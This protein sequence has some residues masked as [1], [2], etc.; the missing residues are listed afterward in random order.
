M[1]DKLIFGCTSCGAIIELSKDAKPDFSKADCC[2]NPK[3]LLSIWGNHGKKTLTTYGEFLSYQRN[4][5]VLEN[6][7]GE[8]ILNIFEEPKELLKKPISNYDLT[9]DFSPLSLNELLNYNDKD[10]SEWLVD[11]I[12]QPKKIGLLGG[13]AGTLKSWFSL[14]LAFCVA[15]GLP[16]VNNFPTKQGA[17]LFIDRENARTELKERCQLIKKG[18][19]IEDSDILIYFLSEQSIKLDVPTGTSKLE[20]F[21]KQKNIC[22]VIVD[23]YRRAISF[24][25]NDAGAVSKFFVD[26]IKPICERTGVS[27]LFIHHHKKGKSE[28]NEMDLIRGSSD[29]VN[30][31]DCVLQ[32]SRNGEIMTIKQTK[33]RGAKELQPFNLRVETDEDNYFK[34]L[35]EGTYKP[36]DKVHKAVE[37]ILLWIT[38]NKIEEFKTGQAQEIAKAEGIKKTNFHTALQ[39]LVD[40][41]EIEKQSHGSYKVLVQKK[42][43][44][45]ESSIEQNEQLNNR[46]F[47]S[48][49]PYRAEQLNNSKPLICASCGTPNA[50][51]H[52]GREWLCKECAYKKS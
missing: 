13:S 19:N 17:V 49:T 52:N 25:E 20:S 47:K 14:N 46:K 34:F 6:E 32:V 15:L 1:N 18:L 50:N 7:K 12:I 37:V 36:L 11:G 5:F 40:K 2:K 30:F 8:Y 4:G 28:G 26:S 16:F 43:N 48:L 21:I 27:F 35:Y 24:E 23:T 51:I 22:L 39:E 33:N 9:G 44:S 41:G 10:S 3:Y 38:K 29:F 31:V 42:L 45:S